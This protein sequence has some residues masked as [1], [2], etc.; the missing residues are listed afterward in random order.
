LGTHKAFRAA[1][2]CCA[3]FPYV[4]K[5]DVK[6]YFPS[7]DHEILKSMIREAVD[8]AETLWLI[9][10]II[11]AES[12][13]ES[14]DPGVGEMPL[15][16]S[17]R[18]R[19]IPIRNL[20]SQF[21][22][23]VYLDPLD[24]FVVETLGCAAYLRY[25]D[26][27]VLFHDDKRVLA[28]WREEIRQFLRG[29]RLA[30]HPRKQEVFPVKNGLDFLGYRITPRGVRVRKSNVRAFQRRMK[31]RVARYRGGSIPAESIA[32]SVRS[33]IAHVSHADSWRLRTA[34]LDKIVL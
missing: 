6:R 22:A 7:I 9:D 29:L 18:R 17:V 8:D 19:G 23:N 27:F 2:R 30:L 31:A 26:D 32:M 20:T 16:D 10:A 12:G 15:F 5:C 28:G 4:L 24:H 25:V 33:W 11:D 1:K 34:V 13:C 14:Y 3:R 21:F